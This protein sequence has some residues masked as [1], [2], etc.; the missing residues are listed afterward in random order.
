[1]LAVFLAVT[2]LD[3]EGFGTEFLI[4]GNHLGS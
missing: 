1:V 3:A 2:G 4:H